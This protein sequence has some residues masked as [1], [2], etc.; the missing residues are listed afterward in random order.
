MPTIK[1]SLGDVQA[2]E[3]LPIAKY[4]AEIEAMVLVE[5]KDEDHFDGIKV[6]YLVI[7]GDYLGRRQSEWL[8]F[9]PKADFMMKRWFNRFGQGDLEDIVFDDDT[10]EM[11]SPDLTGAR[12]IFEVKADKK[13]NDGMRTSLLS[14]EEDAAPAAP[15]QIE[16]GAEPAAPVALRSTVQRPASVAAAPKR[17]LR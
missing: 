16:A 2:F 11:V 12:V 7:D 14:Y 15:V 13:S 17:T 8:S 3:S 5:A 9:S 6:T 4:L 10:L 1:V